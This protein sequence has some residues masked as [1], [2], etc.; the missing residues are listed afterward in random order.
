[1][2]LHKRL[3][4][5]LNLSVAQISTLLALLEYPAMD[6]H[7]TELL[8]LYPRSKMRH[9]VLD[10]LHQDGW[11]IFHSLSPMESQVGAPRLAWSLRP[12]RQPTLE[13]ALAD[14]QAWVDKCRRK[15]SLTSN[16]LC[17]QLYITPDNQSHERAR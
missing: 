6:Y 3:A 5:I 11:I 7:V 1:M 15:A 4:Q 2:L 12:D 8:D 13:Q 9:N 10:P 17:R 16:D 14:A